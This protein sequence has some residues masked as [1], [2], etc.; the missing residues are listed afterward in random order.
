VWDGTDC[1]VPVEN[2]LPNSASLDHG[3]MTPSFGTVVA[4][5]IPAREHFH[6]PNTFSLCHFLVLTLAIRW[7]KIRNLLVRKNLDSSLTISV[8]SNFTSPTKLEVQDESA[9]NAQAILRQYTARMEQEG[10]KVQ[11][12]TTKQRL[13][14]F[15][16]NARF[17][18][19]GQ[20]NVSTAM[21]GSIVAFF[22][23]R[24]I[25]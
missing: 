24:T 20:Q 16:A 14:C 11:R 1:P 19:L 3:R 7:L 25:C 9:A 15:Q 4:I 6:Q 18:A 8:Q 5:R 17:S 21:T 12:I 2:S 10:R 22:D 23:K 13:K